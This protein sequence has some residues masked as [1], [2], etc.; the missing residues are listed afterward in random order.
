MPADGER[1]LRAD[2]ARLLGAP[3]RARIVGDAGLPSPFAVGTLAGAAVAAFADAVSALAGGAP[4]VVHRDRCATWFRSALIPDGWSPPPPWDPVA[5]DYRG[6]DGWI[7]LH[8]NAPHHRAA[9]LRVLGVP[10]ERDAV[11]KAVAA[12][13][14]A[15]LEA[16]VV[17]AGGCAA[18][19]RTAADWAS[20][21]E[22]AAVADEPLI[23]VARTDD[24]QASSWSPGPDRPLDG[25]RVL[26]LTRVLAGP[27]ATRALSGLGATVLRVDPP[28]W[29]EPG[30]VPDMTLGKR[31]A[32]LD[33]RTPAG[34]ARLH[35]LLAGA[36]VLVHGYRPGALEHLGLGVDD[37]RR[38]RPGL[39]EV[40]LDA[41]GWAGP[42]AGRRGFDSL[43]QM[44]AG[45]AERGMREAGA[46][47]PVPLP[48]QA[49][50]HATGWLLAAAA[51]ALL[52]DRAADG[53]GGSARLSLARTAAALTALP[54]PDP[55]PEPAQAV[56]RSAP[57]PI[58]TPW[59]PA[60]IA[61]P[62]FAVAGVA[63]RF[64]RGPA[65][66]GTDAPAWP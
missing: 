21:P 2:V 11:A 29:D 50:D 23:R 41:Y 43:V 6:A 40:A 32:R 55:V 59:G 37:R 47:R 9:A 65:P 34:R 16:D 36:D 48:V 45:I 61:P 38:I 15:A 53:R 31:T 39:V 62:P 56:A 19:M 13:P 14:V 66:L 35:E 60:A 25:V 27:V 42:W 46:D 4:A 7:R 18:R 8:T 51:V 20:S 52:R 44:S 49:L 54:G 57:T 12:L 63:F 28:D 5:G 26:D 17:A 64:D 3:E 58:G 24:G 30:V 33:A 22:G 1:V 10:A